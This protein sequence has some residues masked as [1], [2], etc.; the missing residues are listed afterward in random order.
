MINDNNNEIIMKVMSNEY[1]EM[2]MINDD[3][4]VMMMKMIIWLINNNINDKWNNEND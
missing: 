1:N 3:N 2:I 4:D